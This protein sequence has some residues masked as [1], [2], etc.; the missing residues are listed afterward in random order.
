MNT[1]I[2]KMQEIYN[3][4]DTNG[5]AT[6]SFLLWFFGLWWV[7]GDSSFSENDDSNG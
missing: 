2:N 3:W 7:S 1:K 5:V 6:A 4:L